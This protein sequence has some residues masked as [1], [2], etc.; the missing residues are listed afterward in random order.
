MQRATSSESYAAMVCLAGRNRDELLVK[1][2]QAG[3]PSAFQELREMYARRLYQTVFAITKNRE[4]SEDA[5]QDSF[6][7][8]YIGLKKFRGQASFYSWLTRI[9]INASLMILRK[10]RA[11]D[12][13]SSYPNQLPNQ[14][15]TP[16]DVKDGAPDPE[17]R[18]EQNQRQALLM[19][20]IHK[21]RPPL[22]KVV[23]LRMN[24]ECSLRETAMLLDISESAAKSRLYRARQRLS[25]SPG[26]K[27]VAGRRSSKGDGATY[28]ETRSRDAV[29]V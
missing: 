27:A 10:K 9:A 25:A 11:R 23:E 7:R 4:D 29:R 15:P 3:V 14:E 24:E 6:L 5:L 28:R 21:L 1:A 8:A 22:R 16:M 20:A 18:Y 2:A 17:L 13:V 26:I 12:R 19:M